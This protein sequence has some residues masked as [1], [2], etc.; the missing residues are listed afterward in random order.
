[1]ATFTYSAR[2]SRGELVKGTIEAASRKEAIRKISL[3]RLQPVS[4]GESAAAVAKPQKSAF[5]WSFLKKGIGPKS[6]ANK[7]VAETSLSRKLRLPFLRSLSELVGSGMPVGD[8]IRLLSVRLQD[9][10]LKGLSQALWERI[11]GGKS[12]S[13]AMADIPAVFDRSTVFLI[14]SGEAT[15]N[16]K[17][18]LTRLVAHFEEQK[19]LQ[20][21]VTTAMAYPILILVVAFGVVLFSVFVLL[22]RLETMLESLG[23][24]LPASTLALMAASNLLI[25]YG[26]YVIVGIVLVGL[27]WW[28][29]KRTEKGALAWDRLMLKVPILGN[30]LRTVDVLQISQTMSVLL[31]NGV[32]TVETLRMTQNVIKNRAIRESFAEARQKV[33]EGKSISN[34]L[35]GTGHLPQLVLDMLSVGENTG[36]IV[37]SLKQVG[38]LFQKNLSRQLDGFIG[39]LSIGVLMVVF[40]FVGFI[41]FA[42]ISAVF[43]MSASFSF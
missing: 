5:D 10:Q 22:P 37:Y 34:A 33:T 1:M 32:T 17:E 21:K 26:L 27:S 4:V 2:D 11:S 19:E 18:I 40:G 36:N 8:A 15:G 12:V 43:Q 38:D 3:N 6:S 16:L 14:E 25:S 20:S 41:A 7:K 29:W 31:E 39:T 13:D 24:D 42:I 30:F 28:Q 35:Q 9:Q 23:G